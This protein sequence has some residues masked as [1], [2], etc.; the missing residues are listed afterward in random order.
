LSLIDWFFIGVFG[1]EGALFAV[2]P[3]K[4]R[5]A[6]L[7]LLALLAAAVLGML[8]ERPWQALSAAPLVLLLA[9][10]AWRGWRP[11]GWIQ[12]SGV[13]VLLLLA[14]APWTLAPPAPTLPSPTGPYAL[15][16]RIFRW[17]DPARPETATADPNDRRNVVAQVWYP[18]ATG[19]KGD[20]PPYIDGLGRLPS[21][22][23]V[24]PGFMMRGY[25][26]I[27]THAVAGAP[28]SPERPWPVVLFSPGYGAP[29]AAYTGL[30]TE[31][32]SRGF[33]VVAIDHPYESAVVELADGTLATNIAPAGD[34]DGY[35]SRQQ[36]IR[37]AD[38]T[39]VI[40]K[41]AQ[42]PALAG[43]LDLAR[44]VAIG[45]SFGGPSAVL[46]MTRDPRVRAAAN[47]D[48]TPYGELPSAHL[49]RPFLLIESDL[50]EAPH[51]QRYVE[52][53]AKLIANA[54]AATR[55]LTIAHANHYSFTDAPL[56]LAPPARWVVSLIAGGSA[57]AVPTQRRTADE[58]AA[59]VKAA[60]P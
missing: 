47:L 52:G 56:M 39:F 53:N 37:A 50:A 15:G 54:S 14:I 13:I 17:V 11:S 34:A 51:G 16:S 38:I 45:H 23:S 21:M 29:R 25:G 35:M 58:V 9:L 2:L 55:R 42:E 18:A 46:A 10:A 57:G 43:R 31:L 24:L 8:F 41:L 36:D 19:A 27:D 1:F 30:V 5:E 26:R 12:R 59:F 28:V 20:H 48:G 32:A 3:S 60:A 4:F 7:A 33:V 44:I 49:D 6:G 22:V 40:N